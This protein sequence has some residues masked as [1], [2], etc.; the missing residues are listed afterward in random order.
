MPFFPFIND[1][2]NSMK[3]TDKMF[4]DDTKLNSQ[5]SKVADCENRQDDLN[6][7]EIW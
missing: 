5:I 7:L 3:E 6:T 4:A 2:S 1:L